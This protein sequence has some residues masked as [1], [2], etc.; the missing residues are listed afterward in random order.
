MSIYSFWAM[1]IKYNVQPHLLLEVPSARIIT[2]QFPENTFREE[3]KFVPLNGLWDFYVVCHSCRLAE[4]P[5]CFAA[6]L[7]HRAG[8]QH[9][10]YTISEHQL[11]KPPSLCFTVLW[12]IPSLA[13]QKYRGNISLKDT[14]AHFLKRTVS[15]CSCSVEL[16]KSA[17]KWMWKS[18]SHFGK[19]FKYVWGE[20]KIW[21]SNLVKNYEILISTMFIFKPF[22][23]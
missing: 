14:K 9:W 4:E 6:V 2:T 1:H 19:L 17:K 13:N 11:P 18:A 23:P 8:P 12:Q 5:V 7:S 15:S 21:A 3:T 10:A 22:F 20:K 16:E